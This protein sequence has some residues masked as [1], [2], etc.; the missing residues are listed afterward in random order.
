MTNTPVLALPDFQK[1]FVIETDACKNGIGTVMM[2]ESRSIAYLSKALGAKHMGLSTCEKKLLVVI[3]AMQKW[4]AYLL[5]HHF[6]I[7]TDH[8]AEINHKLATKM[9]IQASRV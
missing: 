5:G 7:R 1:S 2:Q 4:M 9:G 3:T 6:I 8:E